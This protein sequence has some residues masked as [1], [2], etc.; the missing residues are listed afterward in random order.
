MASGSFTLN[1]TGSTSR[2][3]QFI[4]EYSTRVSTLQDNT[5]YVDVVV[6][7]KKLSG[8]TAATYGQYN[9]N[10][11]C[12]NSTYTVPNT[13]FSVS[14]NSTITLANCGLPVQHNAD[15]T[16]T[17]IL[18]V[19]VGGNVMW[20]NGSQTI[21][22]DTIPRYPSVSAQVSSIGYGI[23]GVNWYTD[24]NC[25]NLWYSTDGGNN[26]VDKGAISG[27]SGHFEITGLTPNTNYN[28]RVKAKRTDS[29]LSGESNIESVNTILLP[30]VV[31]SNGNI[32]IGGTLI[33]DIL[34]TLYSQLT[35]EMYDTNNTLLDTIT[36]SDY[37]TYSYDTTGK[38]NDLYNSIPNATSG[39]FNF[40]TKVVEGGTTYS[41]STSTGTYNVDTA[42]SKPEFTSVVYE[43]TNSD[44]LAITSDNQKIVSNNST[45]KFDVSGITAKNGASIVSCKLTQLSTSAD[46]TI[47]GTTASVS[48]VVVAYENTRSKDITITLTDS[49]GLT[50]PQTIQLDL[51]NYSNPVGTFSVKRESNYYSNTIFLVNATYSHI[52][53]NTLT[54]KTRQKQQGSSTWG[55]YTTLTNGTASTISL[56]NQY[57]WDVE[58]EISD[59]LHSTTYTT[60]VARGMPLMYFDT[61]KNSLGINCFPVNNASVELNG[62]DITKYTTIKT[63]GNNQLEIPM[64]AKEVILSIIAVNNSSHYVINLGHLFLDEL[65]TMGYHNYYFDD[66][67]TLWAYGNI[68]IKF[69]ATLSTASNIRYAYMLSLSYNGTSVLN[70]SYLMVSYR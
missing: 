46:L 64:D 5:S 61:T 35:I 59:S 20:G 45:I 40:I 50:Y 52:G 57:Y 37:G 62:K 56:D 16:K 54:I 36:T 9:V 1:N 7:C 6:K 67:K 47:S 30:R 21:T 68:L 3:I 32:T 4:V 14:P 19:E 12:D 8:S 27:T 22:L 63:T 49:R 11:T 42:T 23:I 48:N 18:N 39:R 55:N 25:D 26:W 66:I 24:S 31:A 58:I 34:N 53:S 17:C 28:I 10:I 13:Q 60:K 15:G 65:D 2:Y 44:T 38:V 33:I 70:N 41:Y 43:D 29:Q 51:V 69:Q